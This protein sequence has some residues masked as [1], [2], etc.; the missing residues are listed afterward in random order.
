MTAGSDFDHFRGIWEF[1][2]IDGYYRSK[3]GSTYH[4]S[5]DKVFRKIE[6]AYQNFLQNGQRNVTF[7][8][9]DPLTYNRRREFKITFAKEGYHK[10]ERRYPPI[11]EKLTWEAK[12]G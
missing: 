6:D 12:R 4:R 10:L 5:R 2:P 1:T 8:M 7:H 11:H 9:S 3:T